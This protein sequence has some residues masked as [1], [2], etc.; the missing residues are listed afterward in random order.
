MCVTLCNAHSESTNHMFFACSNSRYIW[1]RCKL[2]LRFTQTIG[3]LS[4]EATLVKTGFS[5]KLKV[6]ALAK[7]VLAGLFGTYERRET[8]ESFIKKS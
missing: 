6:C 4:E 8:E 2:K 5:K 1:A 7:I 3:T